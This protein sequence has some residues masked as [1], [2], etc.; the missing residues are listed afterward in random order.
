MKR[1]I[2]AAVTVA[3][4]LA[5]LVF[6]PRMMPVDGARQAL[7]QRLSE[8]VGLT[9]TSRE[10]A[11]LTLFPLPVLELPRI[12]VAAPGGEPLVTGRSLR[13]RLGLWS[14]FTGRVRVTD[15]TLE[16]AEILL[17]ADASGI[18][19]WE[20]LERALV[21]ALARS[22]NLFP[23]HLAG[24]RLIWRDEASGRDLVLQDL[25]AR[26]KLGERG[27]LQVEG[28]ALWRN[29][30]VRAELATG[31]TA[32]LAEGQPADV[33]ARVRTELLQ[34]TLSG[35]MDRLSGLHLNGEMTLDT[36]A[37]DRLAVWLSG[38]WDRSYWPAGKLSLTSKLKRVPGSISLTDASLTFGETS[39]TGAV[40]L[41][42][43]GNG[44]LLQG[45]V[46]ASALDL[47]P[48]MQRLAAYGSDTRGWSRAQFRHDL[49]AGF[50]ADLRISADRLG[51]G[52]VILANAALLLDA[53]Q[54]VLTL[55][56]Q[57][58]RT[59]DGAVSAALRLAPSGEALDVSASFSGQGLNLLPLADLLG[60]GR[61]V[62]GRTDFQGQ[63][64]AQGRSPHDLAR[65]L[66]GEI[67]FEARNGVIHGINIAQ[68]LRRL[69]RAPLGLGSMTG[70]RTG[71]T[72][73]AGR[74]GLTR[75]EG[76][77]RDVRLESPELVVTLAGRTD[78][79][80]R[81]LDLAGAAARRSERGEI[82]FA[83]PF[84]LDGSWRFPQLTPDV[85]T[86]LRRSQAAAPLFPAPAP[87]PTTEA[88]PQQ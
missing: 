60:S 3:A 30:R 64:F 31:A 69:E 12:T 50:D 42:R 28:D 14:L 32:A 65:S 75:G 53:R 10:S 73:A 17:I 33:K 29:E 24:C 87:A 74:I 15:V 20:P 54:G 76:L 88:P 85:K 84:S 2:V 49:V 4:L 21:A 5:V 23:I 1:F 58:A 59:F 47:A 55:K 62:E 61:R 66:S 35:K 11:R 27:R 40:T 18:R 26:L 34:F 78:V 22:A 83:L 72:T 43:T 68:L 71:F 7:E 80:D 41:Q 67:A 51:L 82:E 39:A 8:A 79:G 81:T 9:V 25:N 77:M 44:P 45:T 63:L 86:L 19:S 37:A 70:G 36:P 52:P 57:E 13:A 46:A 56:L 6:V 48:L 38:E 16:T